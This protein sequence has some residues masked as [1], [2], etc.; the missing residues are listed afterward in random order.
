MINCRNFKH[1][2]G[3]E[4]RGPKC[5]TNEQAGSQYRRFINKLRLPI[6]WGRQKQQRSHERHTNRTWV[7]ADMNWRTDNGLQT[8]GHLN[9]QGLTRHRW[10]TW[11]IKGRCDK[12]GRRLQGQTGTLG[13]I[14]QNKKHKE[15][16]KSI[17]EYNVNL[18]KP[19]Y[20]QGPGVTSL[21]C[22]LNWYI[23]FERYAII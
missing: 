15:K 22:Q 1:C 8:L 13:V 6:K 21:K 23:Q 11:Q 18:D 9:R 12:T 10:K 2:Q 5:S 20:E 4:F 19:S 7:N 17:R 3:S 16:Q 14:L